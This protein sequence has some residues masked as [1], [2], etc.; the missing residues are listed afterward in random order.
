MES[1]P[2]FIDWYY[3]MKPLNQ[4]VYDS[5]CIVPPMDEEGTPINGQVYEDLFH[6]FWTRD[7][8]SLPW[9]SDGYPYA[10]LSDV[11]NSTDPFSYIVGGTSL[12]LT[13]FSTFFS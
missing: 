2:P 10:N 3:S 9:E 1:L 11:C 5:L 12:Y 13:I 8:F 6:K 7:H 4:T